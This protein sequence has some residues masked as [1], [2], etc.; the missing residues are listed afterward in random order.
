MRNNQE[1]P[2]VTST[3]QS[4]APVDVGKVTACPGQEA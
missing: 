1:E 3:S 4:A 2:P